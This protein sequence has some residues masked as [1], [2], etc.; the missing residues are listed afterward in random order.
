MIIKGLGLGL[1]LII[2]L[3]AQAQDFS[4]DLRKL[5]E[6]QYRFVGEL[7]GGYAL[8]AQ[9]KAEGL[10]FGLVNSQGKALLPPRYTRIE[11]SGELFSLRDSAQQ[12][13]YYLG[14]GD[15][16]IPLP[17]ASVKR[18]G[19]ES[20][21]VC[22]EEGACGFISS[23]GE[24]R[25]FMIY[26]EPKVWG[27]Y[28]LAQSHK[29]PYRD[30]IFDDFGRIKLEADNIQALDAH[31]FIVWEAKN[32]AYE[33]REPR[34]EAS[35]EF[36]DTCYAPR[37]SQRESNEPVLVQQKGQFHWL[38]VQWR[39]GE[40]LF[41]KPLAGTWKKAQALYEAS[42][43][44]YALQDAQ[45]SWALFK[46]GEDKPVKV[47]GP[48]FQGGQ[49]A[50]YKQ[51]GAL[52]HVRAK[53]SLPFDLGENGHILPIP[54]TELY[55]IGSSLTNLGLWNAEGQF[56]LPPMYQRDYPF[57]NFENQG[58]A[59]YLRPVEG[60][61]G[62]PILVLQ[63]PKDKTPTL[64]PGQACIFDENG[65]LAYELSGVLVVL[66]AQGREAQVEMPKNAE[67]LELNA[68]PGLCLLKLKVEDKA[69]WQRISFD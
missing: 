69:V 7:Q 35:S 17:Y 6:G 49:G 45:G 41:L 39:R 32:K 36:F 23:T 43:T 5:L 12:N 18:N 24:G 65:G 54:Q 4:A 22:V 28:R 62:Q 68:Q 11:R 58:F 61:T 2:A 26:R 59:L 16:L 63:K 57:I 56:L 64:L 13:R 25:S 14:K 40:D 53:L 42:Q 29:P 38:G 1:C 44:Y 52:Q 33:L 3:A 60:A 9:A 34:R 10:S 8:V 55:L 48:D 20:F 21:L 66:D 37:L 46:A 47:L 50:Y 15:S 19:P 67:L 27:K 31:R 30:F 51:G